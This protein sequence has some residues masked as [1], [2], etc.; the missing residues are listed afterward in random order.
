MMVWTL[1]ITTVLIGVVMWRVWRHSNKT[2]SNKL[3]KTSVVLVVAAFV[4]GILLGLRS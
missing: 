1:V 4:V 2:R 3:W